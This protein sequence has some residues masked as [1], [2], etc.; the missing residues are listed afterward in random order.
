MVFA[1][2]FI[3]VLIAAQVMVSLGATFGKR[4]VRE[5]NDDEARMPSRRILDVVASMSPAER[6]ALF[7]T[8]SAAPIS[9]THK[10]SDV[11]PSRNPVKE[12]I[13]A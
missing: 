9:V 4:I 3:A 5:L 1:L 13:N 2:M 6:V 7:P 11:R 10:K 12:S 8:L